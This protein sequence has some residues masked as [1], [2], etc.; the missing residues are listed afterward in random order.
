MII[1]NLKINKNTTTFLIN[2]RKF[3]YINMKN[4]I[5]L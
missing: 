4:S 5:K 3:L 2:R 1:K